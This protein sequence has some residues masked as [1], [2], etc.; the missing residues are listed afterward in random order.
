MVAYDDI[1]H[2]TFNIIHCKVEKAGNDHVNI[3]KILTDPIVVVYYASYIYTM[4][5]TFTYAITLKHS[6]FDTKKQANLENNFTTPYWWRI[7]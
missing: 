5:L 2:Q 7:L 3:E 1:I 4:P 6:F